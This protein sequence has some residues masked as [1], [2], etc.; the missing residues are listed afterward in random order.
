M[1]KRKCDICARDK[2]VWGGGVCA[3]GHFSCESCRKNHGNTCKIDGTL[4]R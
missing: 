3:K 2:E 1:T 4:I